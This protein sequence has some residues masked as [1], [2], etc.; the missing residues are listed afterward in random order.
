VWFRAPG[1]GQRWH[2][3]GRYSTRAEALTAI[4]SAGDWRVQE[5]RAEPAAPGLFDGLDETA[6]EQN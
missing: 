5:V 4:D 3:A 1:K 2:K 6:D